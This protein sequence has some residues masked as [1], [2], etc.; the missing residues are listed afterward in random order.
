MRACLFFDTDVHAHIWKNI[1]F[2]A[3]LA[4]SREGIISSC[5]KKRE[6]TEQKNPADTVSHLG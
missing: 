4:G 5:G 6:T 1:A 2:L 3:A